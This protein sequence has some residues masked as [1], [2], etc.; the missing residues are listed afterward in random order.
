MDQREIVLKKID[1]QS[2]EWNVQIRYL[3]SKVL[4]C[5]GE[6]RLKLEKYVNH[7]GSKLKSI[8]KNTNK[9]KVAS[10]GVWDKHGDSIAQCWE[11]LVHNVDYVIANYV[12]IFNL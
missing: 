4:D 7:L 10:A 5:D 3:Q 11:E 8:E 6:T 9:L 1:A 2:R 12:R